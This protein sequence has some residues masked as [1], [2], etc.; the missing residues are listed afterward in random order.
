[1]AGV[2]AIALAVPGMVRT[3]SHSHAGGP[4]RRDG[5]GTPTARRRGRRPRPRR[6]AAA[7]PKPYDAT[8]PVDLGGTPGVT[9]EQQ[10]EAEE[11]VTITLEKLPQFADIP[12]IEAMGYR[13]IGDAGTGN[14]HFM[15]WDLIDDDRVLDPDYPES[16][17]FDVDRETG[18]K[19]LVAA[20]FMRTPTTRST[21]CPRSAATWSSGTSTTTSAYAGE[22]NAWRVADV[23]PPDEECRPGTFRLSEDPVPMV[24]VWILPHPCGPFAALE[25]VGGGQIAAGE[26][27][28]CDHAHGASS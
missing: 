15:N 7:T 28:L 22:T 16:L 5:A 20:M 19:T 13:S 18:Q 3:G 12:T 9:P 8:L 23:A 11:L 1:M 14:E 21:P 26:Q 27:R 6:A 4:R 25:G 17:V 2:A 24:H 10:A